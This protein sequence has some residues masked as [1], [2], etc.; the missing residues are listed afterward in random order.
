[1]LSAPSGAP[2]NVRLRNYQL[3]EIVVLWDAVSS[4]DTN[5]KIKGYT[6]YY[7]EYTDYYTESVNIADP[8]VNQAVLRGL[9]AG[10]KYQIAV[11]AFTSVGGGPWSP[12]LF[13]TVGKLCPKDEILT[14]K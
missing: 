4:Q 10:Q 9:N 3:N 14:N 12:W 5:G 1:M 7:R 8:S 13:V 2:T 11:A 6:V